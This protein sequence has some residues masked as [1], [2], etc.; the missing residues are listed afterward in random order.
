MQIVFTA[1][2][3]DGHSGD[4]NLLFNFSP[5]NQIPCSYLIHA[6]LHSFKNTIHIEYIYV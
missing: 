2:K 1:T 4:S 5:F 6:T 3:A